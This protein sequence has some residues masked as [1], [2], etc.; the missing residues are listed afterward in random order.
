MEELARHVK[1]AHF[2]NIT[3]V[4]R[5]DWDIWL[6][7][8]V[9]ECEHEDSMSF[10]DYLQTSSPDRVVEVSSPPQVSAPTSPTSPE[11]DLDVHGA[12][13]LAL[14]YPS[15]SSSPPPPLS[16]PP[17]SR[18]RSFLEHLAQSSPFNSPSPIPIA[19]SPELED[20]IH[21]TTGHRQPVYTP[22]TP[23]TSPKVTNDYQS[24]TGCHLTDSPE[25]KL[26]VVET[27][28][29]ILS[30]SHPP[31]NETSAS[32][33][34][35]EAHLTQISNISVPH[36]PAQPE[37]ALVN[38]APQ[39][40]VPVPD[41][42][43]PPPRRST[44]ARSRTPA[45]LPTVV[46]PKKKALPPV[47]ETEP[48][49]EPLDRHPTPAPRR[50]SSRRRATSEE[51]KKTPRPR[52]RARSNSSTNGAKKP[53]GAVAI[54][55]RRILLVKLVY[56]VLTVIHSAPIYEVEEDD[57]KSLVGQHL[58]S[59]LIS[60]GVDIDPP[61]SSEAPLAFV[62]TK[63]ASGTLVAAPEQSDESQETQSQQEPAPYSPVLS[64]PTHT[65]DLSTQFQIQTQAPYR[66]Q[67]ES[68]SQ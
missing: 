51:P 17:I 42:P 55:G 21:S 52:K 40:P 33:H 5:K 32:S 49:P 8:R 35:V 15:T 66:S 41:S 43:P 7:S 6:K 11:H 58:C 26:E 13:A 54:D 18:K 16:T 4:K 14:T 48:G 63:I 30:Y 65:W 57:G 46:A 28:K 59:R 34:A 45:P 10:P 20:L 12:T 67:S 50:A 44:R 56:N 53:V 2:N 29:P 31:S 37:H 23:P 19:P 61:K 60:L 38:D 36:S 3:A 25:R 47:K 39:D 1:F 62:T 64:Y 22:T 24:P 9:G 68:Q 27:A